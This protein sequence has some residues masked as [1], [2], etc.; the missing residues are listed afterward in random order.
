MPVGEGLSDEVLAG[1]PGGAED[2]IGAHC[3]SLDESMVTTILLADTP[4][5]SAASATGISASPV[6]TT[7]ASGAGL[8]VPSARAV[9]RKSPKTAGPTGEITGVPPQMLDTRM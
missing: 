4:R 1:L 9:G 5:R 2:E 7:R 3:C 8:Y 6:P